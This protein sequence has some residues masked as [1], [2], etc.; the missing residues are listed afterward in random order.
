[1][2]ASYN[3]RMRNALVSL[4]L[5]A[6]CSTPSDTVEIDIK[7]CPAVAHV[8]VAIQ[9]QQ[10]ARTIVHI[11]DWHFISQE[12]AHFI[13]NSRKGAGTTLATSA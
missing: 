9:P 1:M 13:C 5:L 6:G 3:P 12:L 8:E 7:D 11:L 4:I 10:T 2:N